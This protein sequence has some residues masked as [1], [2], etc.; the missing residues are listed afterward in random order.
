MVTNI[1]QSKRVRILFGKDLFFIFLS[2]FFQ[3]RLDAETR[4]SQARLKV[5]LAKQ[6]N[7]LGKPR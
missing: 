4:E 2:R 5:F 7:D 6:Y 3:W 1:F